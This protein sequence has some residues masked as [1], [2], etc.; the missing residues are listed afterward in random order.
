VHLHCV[1]FE[2]IKEPLKI[3]SIPVSVR[4]V[5][6]PPHVYGE[7]LVNPFA[8]KIELKAQR[9][10]AS[11]RESVGPFGKT[12]LLKISNLDNPCPNP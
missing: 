4:I 3:N 5:V 10:G 12:F 11:K 6:F 2:G 7:R 8:F 1:K 9:E